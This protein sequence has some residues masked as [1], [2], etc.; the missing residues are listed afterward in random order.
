MAARNVMQQQTMREAILKQV[1]RDIQAECTA[2][3]SK[4]NPSILSKVSSD[5]L[6]QLLT[7]LSLR[8][9]I[10]EPLYF[11]AAWKLPHRVNGQWQNKERGKKTGKTKGFQ[12]FQ[13]QHQFCCEVAV[14]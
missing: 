13:W 10:K 4:K 1:E 12:Q 11:L 3:C 5:N 14:P 8:S 2:L 9:C 6:M 7:Q